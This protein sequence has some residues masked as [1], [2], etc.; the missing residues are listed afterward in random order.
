VAWR[1]TLL[2]DSL[3][4]WLATEADATRRRAILEFL[5]DLCAQR[6]RLDGAIPVP[7]T[8]LPAFAAAVPGFEVVVVWVI[9][10]SYEEIAV[11]YLYD[12]RRDQ[13]F[14]G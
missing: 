10:E 5:V 4:P 1:P 9:A 12:V 7:G 3:D 8:Q 14:G 11:R 2:E 13:R 6:G